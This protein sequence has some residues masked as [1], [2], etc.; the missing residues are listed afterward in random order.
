MEG[1]MANAS[2]AA[3]L[4]GDISIAFVNTFWGLLVAVPALTIFALLRS[5]IDAITDECGATAERMLGGLRVRP[6]PTAQQPA[7]KPALS[8]ASGQQ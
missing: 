1:G 3:K 6:A 4:S 8:Q 2:N 7:E 5:R